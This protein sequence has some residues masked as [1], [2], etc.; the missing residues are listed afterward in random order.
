MD[1]RPLPSAERTALLA[2]WAVPGIGS[3]GL[4]GVRQWAAGRWADLVDT[5][6]RDWVDGLPASELVD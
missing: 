2:L 4:G 3:I 6:A 5:P 1:T